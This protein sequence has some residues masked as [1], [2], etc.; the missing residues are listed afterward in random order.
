MEGPLH[1]TNTV[2]CIVIHALHLTVFFLVRYFCP[3]TFLSFLFLDVQENENR[4]EENCARRF[5]NQALDCYV[6]KVLTLREM[7]LNGMPYCSGQEIH[8]YVSIT[9]SLQCQGNAEI[10][11]FF[12]CFCSFHLKQTE[13]KL[14]RRNLSPK[15]L[16]SK[17]Q[18]L[19]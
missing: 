15:H 14:K 1:K 18:T 8:C 4:R 10:R 5:C 16:Q 6:R 9:H 19:I 12:I 17:L 7:F 3:H 13:N 2:Y 11:F